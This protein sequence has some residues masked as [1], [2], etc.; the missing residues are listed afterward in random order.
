VGLSEKDESVAEVGRGGLLSAG[1][2]DAFWSFLVGIASGPWWGRSAFRLVVD[3]L[4]IMQFPS[5]ADLERTEAERWKGEV[6]EDVM[7]EVFKHCGSGVKFGDCF[8]EIHMTAW[9]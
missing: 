1:G 9:L 4:G 7:E 6:V 3:C 2:E 8:K 5:K